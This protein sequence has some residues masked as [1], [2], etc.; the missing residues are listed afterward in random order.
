MM[1]I[2]DYY[3]TGKYMAF[4]VKVSGGLGVSNF[5]SISFLGLE[6][7]IFTILSCFCCVM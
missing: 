6:L 2:F 7:Y 5:S 1:G 3:N 4:E